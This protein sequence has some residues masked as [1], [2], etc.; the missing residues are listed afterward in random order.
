MSELGQFRQ[1]FEE[2]GFG[3]PHPRVAEPLDNMAEHYELELP[4]KVV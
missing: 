4:L 3:G 1:T 2:G